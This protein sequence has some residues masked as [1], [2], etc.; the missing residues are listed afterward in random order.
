MEDTR[1][2]FPE[3][4]DRLS[5]SRGFFGWL[6]ALCGGLQNRLDVHDFRRK[7]PLIFDDYDDAVFRPESQP[8]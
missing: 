7:M 5:A 1:L 6:K 2:T 3:Y 8:A 4:L